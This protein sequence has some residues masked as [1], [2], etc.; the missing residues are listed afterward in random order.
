MRVARW[1]VSVAAV[2]AVLLAGL[3]AGC[4]SGGPVVAAEGDRAGRAV[5]VAAGVHMVRGLPGEVDADTLGRI[6][7]AGFIVGPDGVL[8]IDTGTSYRHGVALLAEIRRVTDK[9]VRQV[10]ITHTRQEFLFGAMAFREQAIPIAMH[11][12]AAGLMRARCERCLKTLQRQLG[13]DEMRGTEMLKPDREFDDSHAIDTIGRP[14]RVLYFGHSS[15]PGD[16]AVLDERTGSL[17]AGGLI[18]HQ[19]VP[20]VQDSDHDGWLSAL[21]AMRRLRPRVVVPGHG[22]VASAQVL[23]EVQHYLGQLKQRVLDLLQ[24]GVA[25]SAVPDAAE[26]PEA[27]GWDQYDTIHRRN[28]SILFVRHERDL[29]FRRAD[30]KE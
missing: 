7:N 13:D 17:F 18:D 11:N 27:A 3:L 9:P 15:G 20:D 2:G 26:V 23:D 14:V 16:I 28:A 24:S 30:L 19:R 1:G 4:A 6:G 22:P 25:L 21:G 12:K 29:L 10:L 5:E 8:A